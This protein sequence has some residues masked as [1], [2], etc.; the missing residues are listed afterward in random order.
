MLS[1]STGM[2]G[3]NI[4]EN[5]LNKNYEF[6]TP[7]S[8]ELDLLD[9][10]QVDVFIKKNQPD[11]IIHAAGLV[12]G[13]QANINNPIGF[14]VENSDMG[15]NL[16]LAARNNSV[17][18]FLNLGS[19]CMYPKNSPNPLKEQYILS[20]KL[21]PTNEGYALA[22]IYVAKLC[23]YISRADD[24]FHYK[25][26][27]PCNLYGRHDKFDPKNSHMIPAVISKLYDAKVNKVNTVD[28]WGSGKVRREFMYS[29]DLANFI[30]YALNHF[31]RL[32]QYLNVGPGKDY[33]IKDY[34]DKILKII[35]GN[36]KFVHDLTKPEG[37]NQK[38]TD[39]TLLEEF[40]WKASIDLEEGLRE[41]IEY[42]KR[43]MNY[44]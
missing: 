13:I 19:S 7:S 33:S 38:L 9:Y 2:V 44:E 35:G 37:M 17:R 11:I 22:K 6:I 24:N 3:R 25:T 26:I 29:G 18:Y 43:I 34:Y 27:I 42:Y 14:L 23:E 8:K 39:I 5:K 20:G 31:D 15:K 16:V 1:G 32:P 12:G 21:E 10:N 36:I 30:Y 40:G 4:L 41:T 28:F